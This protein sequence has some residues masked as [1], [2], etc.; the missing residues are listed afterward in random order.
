M[1]KREIA[2]ARKWEAEIRRAR[3]LP[4]FAALPKDLDLPFIAA[5]VS[6]E[7]LW[8]WFAGYTKPGMS[9]GTGD[10]GH[11][12][13][14]FQIDD[15]SHGDF[16]RRI[17]TTPEGKVVPV[18]WYPFEQCRYALQLFQ[19]NLKILHG[20]LKAATAAYNCGAGNVQRMLRA[21]RH[22]DSRTM[23]QDYSTDVFRRRTDWQKIFTP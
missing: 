15:R 7:T 10:G 4:E 16:L 1:I 18:W 20:S 14:F 12:H 17:H 22:V 23:G 11:G 6:R 3:N 13:G 19:A 5:L 2:T 9:N 8:G 21:G